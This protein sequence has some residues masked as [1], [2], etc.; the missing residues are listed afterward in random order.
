MI[1]ASGRSKTS[2]GVSLGCMTSERCV[3]ETKQVWPAKRNGVRGPFRF[4]VVLRALRPSV[5]WGYAQS[6]TKRVFFM[7]SLGKRRAQPPRIRLETGRTRS[8][9]M[10]YVMKHF[11]RRRFSIDQPISSCRTANHQPPKCKRGEPSS[12]ALSPL[13]LLGSTKMLHVSSRK[14]LQHIG[15]ARHS[16]VRQSWQAPTATSAT[17]WYDPPPTRH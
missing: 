13:C 1:C 9:S 4:K 16:A 6:E 7:A 12:N 11:G 10:G 3:R 8:I 5:Y 14:V 15:V 17:Q 2:I